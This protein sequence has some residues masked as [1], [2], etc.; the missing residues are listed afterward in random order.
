[1]KK[2]GKKIKVKKYMLETCFYV[3]Q[4]LLYCAFLSWDPSSFRN[5]SYME[6]G[7]NHLFLEMTFVH[8]LALFN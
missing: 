8:E 7:N 6:M 3:F 2:K 4:N 1:M 5:M